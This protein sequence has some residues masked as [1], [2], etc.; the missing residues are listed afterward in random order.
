MMS[1][2][3]RKRPVYLDNH[4]TTPVDPQV[5]D[6]ILPYYTEKFGNPHSG[7]HYYGWEAREAVEMARQ[8]VA[9]IIGAE[10]GEVYFTT[11]ATES[12][13][14]AIK[15][16]ARMYRGRKDHMVS[17]VSEHMCVLDSLF[18]ME[19]EGSQVTYLEVGADG[20]VTATDAMPAMLEVAEARAA[21]MGLEIIAFQV[22]TMGDIAF[23]DNRF[24]AV[25]CRFGLM[26]SDDPVRTL[27]EA[28]RVLKPGRKAAFMTHGTQERNTLSDILER[29]IK[30]V[31][32]KHE[33]SGAGRR[34]RFSEAGELRKV[35]TAAGF[36]NVGEREILKTVTHGRNTR[37]WRGLLERRHGPQLESLR[38]EEL[39]ELNE[40]LEMAFSPYLSG[41]QYKLQ[42]AD[43]AGWGTA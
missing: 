29:V 17:C 27:R 2:D 35:F 13:N 43:M 19:K 40:A 42:S 30:D 24:D 41:D 4:A 25:T 22:T 26:S 38:A 6:A 37:F 36:E 7:S 34:L 5:L 12:N 18:N 31:L 32:G 21:K 1:V 15:G 10:P 33:G 14:L 28:R 16:I 23:D 9:A 8:Q 11:G 39:A 20:S 3:S